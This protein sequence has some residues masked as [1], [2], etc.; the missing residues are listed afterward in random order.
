MSRYS[1]DFIPNKSVP[2]QRSSGTSL[3]PARVK[4]IIL[5]R[6]HP[7][8]SRLGEGEAIGAVKYELIGRTTISDDTSE[9]PTAYP[10]NN[11]VRVYP[12]I[13]EI[14][15]LEVAT[16]IAEIS[17][18][19]DSERDPVQSVLSDNFGN[20]GANKEPNL[21]LKANAKKI[22]YT[23]IVGLYNAPNHNAF[24]S[25]DEKKFFGEGVE[26]K[27]INPRKPF[28]GDVIIEGRLGQSIRMTGYDTKREISKNSDGNG[29]PLTVITNGQASTDNGFD[30]LVEDPNIDKSSIYLA[31]NNQIA[32]KQ[33]R[34]R[35]E[36][37]NE[38]PLR[39]DQY[40][41]A[42]VIISS[43]RLYFNAREE[44]INMTSK[45]L[46][47]VSA[48][49]IGLDAEEY[50]GLDAK[51]IYLGRRA[52]ELEAQPVIM[53]E[54]LEVF[55]NQLLKDLQSM[56]RLMSKAETYEKEPIPTVRIAGRV[57]K[58]KMDSLL[59]QINPGGKSQLKSRKV[60]TE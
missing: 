23:T 22:Y 32:I 38:P 10:I 45:N 58:A 56:A 2:F 11:T 26:E 20:L 35:Y 43:G 13:N 48:N 24:I 42:Q 34:D 31:S 49:E 36:A 3:V 19:G 30:S 15:L 53:G 6:T 17:E 5:D 33:A 46:M 16:S 18:E 44:D 14:V 9:L 52:R 51:K 4:D 28:P 8:Y 39:A 1:T 7:E 60:F 12:L 21:T 41:G 54:S 27:S 25:S 29:E 50:I 40:K 47:T 59:S 37:V 55:L 57:L